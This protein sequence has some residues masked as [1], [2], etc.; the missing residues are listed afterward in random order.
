MPR[1]TFVGLE[2]E[3]LA[4]ILLIAPISFFAGSLFDREL[5]GIRA[6]ALF[7]WHEPGSPP[8]RK[9]VYRTGSD[10]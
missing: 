7:S 3:D 4:V 9:R 8:R 5:F 2:Y 6:A 10:S 1:V